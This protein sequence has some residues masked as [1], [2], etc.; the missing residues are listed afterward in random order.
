[1]SEIK[2]LADEDVRRE[3]VNI[4]KNLGVKIDYISDLQRKGLSDRAQIE[5]ARKKNY[6][7]L[8]HDKDFIVRSST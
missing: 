5:F 4:L 7:V 8:T 3:V 6:V 2:I 1:M